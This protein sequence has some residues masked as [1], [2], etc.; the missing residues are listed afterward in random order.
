MLAILRYFLWFSLVLFGLAIVSLNAKPIVFDYYINTITL[1]L[2]F[3]LIIHFAFGLLIGLGF[4]VIN[5]FKLKSLNSRLQ[6]QNKQA[7]V[8]R[9][10]LQALL[11]SAVEN[12]QQQKAQASPIIMNDE[13]D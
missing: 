5:Q 7:E 9:K 13:E 11:A 10:Q 12:N 3:I 8:E 6:H 4:N 2:S 1:P